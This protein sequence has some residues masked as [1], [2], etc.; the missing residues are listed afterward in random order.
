MGSNSSSSS[1]DPEQYG[2]WSS[3]SSD[4]DEKDIKINSLTL[5]AVPMT[6]TGKRVGLNIARVVSLGFAEI[7]CE[8]KRISHNII[9]V[10]TNKGPDYVLEWLGEN[11]LRP[12]YYAKYSPIDGSREYRPSNMT[13]SDLRKIM[14]DY[15]GEGDCKDHSYLWWKKIKQK[16]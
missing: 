8:G 11:K 5:K 4:Y 6:T 2:K 3:S 13:V 16:Y 1:F 10:H 14:E 9:E 15:P 7:G 12:G